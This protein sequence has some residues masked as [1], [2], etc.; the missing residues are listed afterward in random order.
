MPGDIY[1]EAGLIQYEYNGHTWLEVQNPVHISQNGQGSF[2]YVEAFM[3][4]P[5]A[6]TTAVKCYVDI[7]V[8]T[9]VDENLDTYMKIVP[10]NVIRDG[11]SGFYYPSVLPGSNRNDSSY[12]SMLVTYPRDFRLSANVGTTRLMMTAPDGVTVLHGY[13][14]LANQA[15]NPDVGVHILRK[16]AGLPFANYGDSTYTA[17]G[18]RYHWSIGLGRSAGNEGINSRYSGSTLSSAW[19]ASAG[20][21]KVG[22]LQKDFEWSEDE[23]NFDGWIYFCGSAYYPGNAYTHATKAVPMKVTIPGLKRLLDYYPWAIRKSS[24]WMSC[25]RSGGFLKSRE[26]SDWDDRKNRP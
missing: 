8:C 26:G 23:E 21:F 19:I 12:P 18:K 15:S 3:V 17:N 2:N 16:Q 13:T 11:C 24:T 4:L 14:D 20:W 25:N 22:N 6:G 1:A 10:G 5:G 7:W 9:R